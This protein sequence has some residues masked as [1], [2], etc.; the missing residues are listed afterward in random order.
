MWNRSQSIIYIHFLV[1]V[2]SSFCSLRC[3]RTLRL[4]RDYLRMSRNVTFIHIYLNS[5]S[6]FTMFHHCVTKYYTISISRICKTA[7]IYLH[8]MKNA[9][10]VGPHT[11]LSVE[12]KPNLD[13]L[14]I[15]KF[16][17]LSYNLYIN[18]TALLH[19]G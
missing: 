14:S 18:P 5:G 6:Q 15:I 1:T 3:K 12:N 17:S 10:N 9:L 16:L 11:S 7:N 4:E 19:L 8:I 2:I 13:D